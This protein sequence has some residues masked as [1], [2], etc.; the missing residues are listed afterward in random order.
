M[1]KTENTPQNRNGNRNGILIILL[2]AISVFI[3]GLALGLYFKNKD[4]D[5]TE[6]KE[7]TVTYYAGNEVYKA[8]KYGIGEIDF[9]DSP[10]LNG[11]TFKYWSKKDVNETNRTEFSFA[12]LILQKTDLNL[13]AVFEK[14]ENIAVSD[15][16]INETADAPGSALAMKVGIARPSR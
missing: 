2:I 10:A 5:T 1:Q 15:V 7:F 9:P 14:T 8:V 12:N 6:T 13:Y 11:K 4:A 16:V 3:N